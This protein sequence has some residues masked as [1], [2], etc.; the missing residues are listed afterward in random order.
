MTSPR[1]APQGRNIPTKQNQG[2]SAN[3]HS[4]VRC[5]IIPLQGRFRLIPGDR[6]QAA[7]LSKQE[8]NYEVV[9]CSGHEKESGYD[10]SKAAIRRAVSGMAKYLPY[11]I[12]LFITLSVGCF[13]R[14]DRGWDYHRS[15]DHGCCRCG[16]LWLP[17]M[18]GTY[19]Q[20]VRQFY[21][22]LCS[23]RP[24]S[25]P[26][27]LMPRYEQVLYKK[28]PTTD[29]ATEESSSDEDL[30]TPSASNPFENT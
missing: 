24:R 19:S 10:D 6:C 23:H 11:F 17:Q 12:S 15:G 4:S 1:T 27:S 3:Y 16:I 14:E 2:T 22:V 9:P 8:L 21:S 28:L 25:S 5:D 20:N 30:I 26:L 13:C 7:E 29:M 18:S